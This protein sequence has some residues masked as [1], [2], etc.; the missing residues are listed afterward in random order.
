[1]KVILIKNMVPKVAS[2]FVFVIRVV[3][4]MV[5]DK[6]AQNPVMNV[7]VTMEYSFEIS[8]PL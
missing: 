4:Q 3:S 1:M 5:S 2:G 6:I 8:L 7:A